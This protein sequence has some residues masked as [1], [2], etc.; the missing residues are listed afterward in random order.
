MENKGLQNLVRFVKKFVEIY[1]NFASMKTF[2]YIFIFRLDTKSQGLQKVF[3]KLQETLATM[4]FKDYFAFCILIGLSS[5]A[6]SDFV[7][8]PALSTALESATGSFSDLFDRLLSSLIYIID[9]FH[10]LNVLNRNLSN[11][12]QTLASLALNPTKTTTSSSDGKNREL[13]F[14]LQLNGKII[15][16]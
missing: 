4:K 9:T 11:L 3:E 6:P 16:I 2:R 7:G 8:F 14:W 10:P 15:C 1:L 13:N 5:G 12:I